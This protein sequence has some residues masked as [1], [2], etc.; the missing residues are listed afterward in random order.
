[1]TLWLVVLASFGAGAAVGV[2]TL[3]TAIAMTRS[4]QE[5]PR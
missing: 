5:R 3:A 1:M 2:I 4:D